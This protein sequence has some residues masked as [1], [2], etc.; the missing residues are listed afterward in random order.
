[1][2]RYLD[3]KKDIT[4]TFNDKKYKAKQGDSIASAL[5]VN[6]ILINRTTYN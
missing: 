4:F 5:F 1:M 2:N 6:D 3:N